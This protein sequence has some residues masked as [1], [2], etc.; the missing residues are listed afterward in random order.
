MTISI[1]HSSAGGRWQ[2]Y[3]ATDQGSLLVHPELSDDVAPSDRIIAYLE[4]MTLPSALPADLRRSIE[5]Q[6]L[7]EP[8][9]PRVYAIAEP[10]A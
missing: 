4:R 9:C 1:Q 6:A 2:T 7:L 8:G 5:Q 10:T 3:V